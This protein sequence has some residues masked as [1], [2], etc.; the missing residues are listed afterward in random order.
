[1]APVPWVIRAAA[2]VTLPELAPALVMAIVPVVFRRPGVA[3]VAPHTHREVP[4]A[5]EIVPVLVRSP[6]PS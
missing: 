2:T 6:V 4:A 3:P 1:M 5:T